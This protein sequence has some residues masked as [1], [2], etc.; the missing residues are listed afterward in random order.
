MIDNNVLKLIEICL[1]SNIDDQIIIDNLK[2]LGEVLEQNERILSSFEKYEK[3]ILSGTLK[4]G[5]MHTEKFWKEHFKKF[6]NNQFKYIKELVNMLTES[7][8]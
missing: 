3:E 1:K 4:W 8:N 2:N 6:E 5:P 7:D